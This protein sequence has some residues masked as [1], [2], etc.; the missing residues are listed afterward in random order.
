MKELPEG[1][2]MFILKREIIKIITFLFDF[3]LILITC[4]FSELMNFNFFFTYFR[5]HVCGI[6]KYFHKKIVDRIFGP[7]Y[8]LKDFQDHKN[9]NLIKFILKGMVKNIFK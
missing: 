2:P 7:T 5:D 3:N 4:I 1:L 9:L 8:T 6:L